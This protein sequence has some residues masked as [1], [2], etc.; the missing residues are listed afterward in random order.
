MSSRLILVKYLHLRSFGFVL[1]IEKLWQGSAL[2]GMNTGGKTMF[3]VQEYIT[4]HCDSLSWIPPSGLFSTHLNTTNTL[5]RKQNQIFSPVVIKPG[6][7]ARYN[8]VV[9]LLSYV[10][11]MKVWAFHGFTLHARRALLLLLQKHTVR[12]M[13]G[14]T[15]LT[16]MSSCPI[17][18]HLTLPV[19]SMDSSSCSS[20]KIA[21]E[22]KFV[23]AERICRQQTMQV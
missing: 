19:V 5:S 4:T 3:K 6:S 8:D 18:D 10:V 20:V 9:G 7:V 1:S 16:I 13:R 12:E 23:L 15:V 11:L 17:S 2:N 14:L 22:G 21:K